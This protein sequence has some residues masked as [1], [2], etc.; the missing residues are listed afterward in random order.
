MNKSL[1]VITLVLVCATVHASEMPTVK[2]EK[3]GMSSERIQQVERMNQRYI[4]EGK[5]VGLVTAVARDGK[6]VYF[7]SAG[8]KGSEDPRPLA[9]DDLFRIYSMTKPITAVAA[10][11]LYEQ[12]KFQLT[13]PVSKFVPELANLT[14]M[15]DG[16]RTP[17]KTQMTMQQLLSHTA[18]FS[19]GFDA[20]NPV[21]KL[22]I[23][24]DL[25]GSAD[26]DDFASRLGQLPLMFEPGERWHY[27]VAVDVTGLV[28][29]R[30]SGQRFDEYLSE[31][32]FQPL[33]M[34]D[35]FFAVPDVKQSRFLPNHFLDP[36]TKKPRSV[37]PQGSTEAGAEI[38]ANCR[39]MCDYN[40]VT[41]FSG[42]GGLVSTAI[43]Y[44]RFAEAMRNGGELDGARILSP[45]TVAYMATNHLPASVSG[46]GSGEQPTLVD[47]PLTGFGFGLGFGLV[48]D[49]AASGVMGS[50]GEYYWGGAAGTVFWID[51]VEQIV[52]VSMMQLMGGWPSYR[53]DLRVATYQALLRTY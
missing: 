6:I 38:F 11:Q 10:M 49:T 52:V 39:A 27:S 15:K 46:G 8:N 29:Q 2:P 43:D 41:L 4:D 1:I 53:P 32:I 31:H 14:V 25:W 42:G 34:V 9:E 22:Y 26:L 44:L 7:N 21:D 47:Q 18:G 20:N 37:A 33:G 45:K 13:D 48:T 51:P 19:Y 35:T 50:V 30:L 17:A 5:I 40:D 24:A 36:E 12:G 28:V 16:V 3:V 23:E